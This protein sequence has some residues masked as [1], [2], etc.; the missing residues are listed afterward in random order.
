MKTRSV[1]LALMLISINIGVIAQSRLDSFRQGEKIVTLDE[2]EKITKLGADMG[3]WS[4]TSVFGKPGNMV[5]K[6]NC[7]SALKGMKELGI[8][9]IPEGLSCD[10]KRWNEADSIIDKVALSV[11]KLKGKNAGEL[12]KVKCYCLAASF[13]LVSIKQETDKKEARAFALFAGI[14]LIYAREAAENIGISDEVVAEGSKIIKD[15]QDLYSQNESTIPDPE[16][17]MTRVFDWGKTVVDI[18]TKVLVN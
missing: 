15:L 13:Y 10:Q 8:S 9:V 6:V 1:L 18:A 12:F 4:Y 7:E 14:V 3:M 2:L 16:P 11:S 17:Y 5:C